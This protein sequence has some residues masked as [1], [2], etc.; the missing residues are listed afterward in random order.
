MIGTEGTAELELFS[1]CALSLLFAA[2]KTADAAGAAFISAVETDC[3]APRCRIKSPAPPAI[4]RIA[5]A[6]QAK[7]SLRPAEKLPDAPGLLNCS[8]SEPHDSRIQEIAAH[9]PPGSSA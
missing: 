1:G 5:A 8:S 6:P 4:K 7:A 2:G 9:S 3:V